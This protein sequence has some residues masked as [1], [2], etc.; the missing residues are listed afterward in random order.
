MSVPL[1]DLTKNSQIE[2][3][4]VLQALQNIIIKGDFILGNEVTKFEKNFAEYIGTKYCVAV[5]SGSD[6]LLLS[7]KALGVGEGDEFIVP[8]MTFISTATSVIHAGATPVFVDISPDLPLIDPTKIEKKITKKT[9]VIIPVH[10]H[11]Y[12]CAMDE[13]NSIAKKHGFF[14]LEDACQAHGSVY[15]KKKAGSLGNIAAFSFYPSKNLGAYG[16]AGAITTSDKHLYEKL[17]MLR[18]HGQKE[19]SV[20]KI[21]GY[22]SRMD[23]LQAAILNI[24]IK[25]LDKNNK[26]RRKS[27]SLYSKLLRELPVKTYHELKDGQ[28]NYYVF[29]IET[30]KRNKLL[31]FLKSKK[32]FCDVHYATPLHLHP[33]LSFLRYKKG[34]FPNAERFSELSMSLPIFPELAEEKLRFV[35]NKIY[36]FFTHNRV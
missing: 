22:N 35:I 4:K 23:S 9:K 2:K 28:T 16:D 36:R 7:L 18:H 27:A 29:A 11:G 6:A 15:K 32:I 30:E 33:A 14:V 13:I 12:P 10:M 31:K 5:A 25:S 8:A 34:D 20:H 19:K 26:K 24:K 17:K 21:L 1:V 3:K